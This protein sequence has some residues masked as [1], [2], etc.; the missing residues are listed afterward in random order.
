MWV[1][2]I[3]GF[4]SVVQ[5]TP[6]P[7]KVLV[8]ARSYKDAQVIHDRVGVPV[9]TTPHADYGW[10]LVVPREDWAQYLA[11]S[12]FELDYPNFKDAI[13]RQ[14]GWQRAS[15]YSDVWQTMLGLQYG[16]VE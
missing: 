13:H 14:H 3:D 12:T 2:T 11:Q 7:T 10:R 8:R 6:D 16:E 1:F 4:Y 9:Q 5:Y 15:L